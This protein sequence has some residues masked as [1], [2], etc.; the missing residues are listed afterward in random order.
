MRPMNPLLATATRVCA[1]L[2]GLSVT[3]AARRQNP[4]RSARRTRNLRPRRRH[5]P[6]SQRR[7]RRRACRLRRPCIRP[8]HPRLGKRASRAPGRLPGPAKFQ[9]LAALRSLQDAMTPAVQ[10]RREWRAR[11]GHSR[12]RR[13]H[14]QPRQRPGALAGKRPGQALDRQHHQ[15]DDDG[16]LPRGQS[17]PGPGQSPSNAAT[18]MPPRRRTSRPTTGSSSSDVLHLTLIASD[19]AA[20]RVLARVSHG[21]TASFVERMNEKA[22]ELG[23]ET[24]TFADPVGAQSGQHVVRLRPLAA[25]FVC[26]VRR[27]HRADHAD[28]DLHL[29][30]RPPHDHHPQH[31]PPRAWAATSM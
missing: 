14:L 21:G 28:A 3:A 4:L 17:G 29:P 1:L 5:R 7:R 10:D 15:G 26:R 25:D 11:P 19:N 6:H 2:L 23:L 8:R 12:R 18:S 13:D 16:R 27:A 9:R 24:T 20:A 30:D 22:L 31:Q